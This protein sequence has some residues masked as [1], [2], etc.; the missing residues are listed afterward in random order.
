MTLFSNFDYLL[1]S[2]YGKIENS[3]RTIS[4]L[5][6]VRLKLLQIETQLI[7][8]HTLWK[9]PEQSL[10]IMCL[11]DFSIQ[12]QECCFQFFLDG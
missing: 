4:I 9:I 3:C 5:N 8:L 6:N 11:T 12:F 7:G 10:K 1:Y 2:F